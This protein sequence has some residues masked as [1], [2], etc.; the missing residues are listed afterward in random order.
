MTAQRS[1]FLLPGFSQT[2][3]AWADVVTALADRCSPTALA[4]PEGLAFKQTADRLAE[5]GRGVWAGYS[6]GGRV[7]LQIALDHPQQ[8]DR[9]V[10]ISATAGIADDLIRAR[11]REHD[12]QLATWIEAN[13][14][15]AF[16][17]RWLSQPLFASIDRSAARRHRL[18][19]APEIAEQLRLLGQGVQP[20]LWARLGELAMPVAVVA[21]ES[22]TAY[23]SIAYELATAIGSNAG[24]TIIDGAGHAL[25]VEKPA[26]V[27]DIVAG[28]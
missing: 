16:L 1:H 15:E 2:P 17:D 7:A 11:R 5:R 12:D 9:L 6:M 21:G 25:L 18:G 23:R 20:P 10:L 28:L 14:V 13:G 22:D 4:I 3:E 26:A 8:V 27:A 19:S 24:V